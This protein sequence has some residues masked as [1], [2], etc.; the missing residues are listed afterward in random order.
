[1]TNAMDR[2][3]IRFGETKITAEERIR[4]ESAKKQLKNMESL[5]A[6]SNIGLF[7]K[8]KQDLKKIIAQDTGS[9]EMNLLDFLKTDSSQLP[10]KEQQVQKLLAFLYELNEKDPPIFKKFPIRDKS[11][12]I[13]CTT[14]SYEGT[15][16]AYNNNANT[17]FMCHNNYND[18]QLLEVLAHELKHA[19]HWVDMQNYNTYQIHQLN[20]LKEAQA[21]VCGKWVKREFSYTNK[22]ENK[23]ET[24]EY[25]A[26]NNL[27]LALFDNQSNVDKFVFGSL[28]SDDMPYHLENF[29]NNKRLY[30]S[31]KDDY[32]KKLPIIYKD[33]GL[34]RIPAVFGIEKQDEVKIL[35]ILNKRVS[36]KAR[37]PDNLLTQAMHND[38]AQTIQK[39]LPMKD[40]T[41]AYLVSDQSV[42]KLLALACYKNADIY[43]ATQQSGRMTKDDYQDLLGSVLHFPENEICT[44]KEMKERQKVFNSIISLKDKK[45][46]FIISNDEIKE[47][48]AYTEMMEEKESEQFIKYAKK[49]M[50]KI[51]KNIHLFQQIKDDY[52]K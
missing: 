35:K 9:Q 23:E 19:E 13:D 17:I 43:Q 45:G 51:R 32:D 2:I 52:T 36:K 50:E 39:L 8:R 3:V 18:E 49:S 29:L 20:F 37:T 21:D 22:N 6:M 24:D 48:I 10:E 1:M 47:Q 16:G 11:L 27:L 44:S 12:I 34:T 28:A 42:F 5:G 7:K 33:K 4:I 31:Y 46:N 26:I 41:G 30:V 38:D 25:S 14:I 15:G 40:E